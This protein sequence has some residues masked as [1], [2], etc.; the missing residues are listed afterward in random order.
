MNKERILIW[1]KAFDK[2]IKD[3]EEIKNLLNKIFKKEG[4]P[5]T[6]DNFASFIK[7]LFE[8]DKTTKEKYA[9]LI[10]K[11]C[12]QIQG[13]TMLSSDPWSPK[14]LELFKNPAQ[15][16][17]EMQNIEKYF[18]PRYKEEQKD[19][20]IMVILGYIAEELKK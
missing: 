1:L 14:I 10:K 3:E 5:T 2:L 20:S 4:L 12:N 15:L 7:D 13:C 11:S 19:F 16:E 18:T 17:K 6:S 9:D 8:V